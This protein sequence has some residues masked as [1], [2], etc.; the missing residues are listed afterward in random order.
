[1]LLRSFQAEGIWRRYEADDITGVGLPNET[2]KD[3]GFYAQGLWG[4]AYRWIA[5]TRVEY[6]DGNGDNAAD[7][8]RDHRDRWNPS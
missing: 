3:S 4:F 1:M 6:A 5:G 7:P 8:L 2:L